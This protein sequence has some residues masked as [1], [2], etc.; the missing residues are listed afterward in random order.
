LTHTVPLNVANASGSQPETKALVRIEDDNGSFYLLNESK[1]GEYVASSL[2]LSS[3]KKYRLRI[4]TTN[5]K[6]YLSEFVPIVQTP[7]IDSITYTSERA[8][9]HVNI[10]THDAN[11]NTHFYRWSYA[12]TW[13]YDAAFDSELIYKNGQ[14]VPRVE[15]FYKC[16]KTVSSTD[17]L[18]E[19]SVKLQ[20]DIISNFTL[21]V[22]P[23]QS[24]KL[25]SK[26]SILVEQ[27]GLTKSEYDYWLQVKKNTEGLGTLFDPLPSR[28]NGNIQ[29]I[30]N[31]DEPASGYFSA[32]TTQTKRIFI[33]NRNITRP[34]TAPAIITGY[35]MCQLDSAFLE[36]GIHG[37]LIVPFT[38]EMGIAVIGYLVASLP[39]VDCRFGGGTT[40]KPDF[41]Q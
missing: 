8:G 17:V 27:R 6:V 40:V 34:M 2:N 41:W 30:T 11:I 35:E 10:N 12:E 9:V 25:R 16:W 33:T 29:C 14:A 32:S 24:P 38:D 37:E 36:K 4:S 20:T 23:W 15:S 3:S 19:S 1:K 5:Q 7:A 28:V 21:T 31:S 13:V 18:V 26:Y 39:C 22:I